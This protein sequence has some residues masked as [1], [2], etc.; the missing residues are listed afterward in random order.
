MEGVALTLHMTKL[1]SF[2]RI[3]NALLKAVGLPITAVGEG[4]EGVLPTAGG[5][6]LWITTSL[7]I[8]STNKCQNS[9]YT[10]SHQQ[11]LVTFNTQFLA[12]K[13]TYIHLKSFYV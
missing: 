6:A 10:L 5:Y 7:M 12:Q 2:K 13:V 8:P 3:R 9:P 4:L 11:K 1:M